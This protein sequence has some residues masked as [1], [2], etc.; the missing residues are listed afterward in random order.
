LTTQ[1]GLSCFEW[2]APSADW[3]VRRFPAR[4][5]GDAPGAGPGRAGDGACVGARKAI[6]PRAGVK[7]L[8]MTGSALAVIGQVLL[9][10]LSPHGSYAGEIVPGLVLTGLGVSCLSCP[11]TAYEFDSPL[12]D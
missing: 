4:G 9:T 8:I 7:W 2:P 6:L 10:R 5:L 12:R 11:A 3:R 1:P